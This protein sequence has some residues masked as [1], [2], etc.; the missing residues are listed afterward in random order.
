M[1][2]PITG[3][4]PI[5]IDVTPGALADAIMLVVMER[6]GSPDDAGCDWYTDV[7]GNTYIANQDWI[8]SV[9]PKVAAL[10][11]AANILKYDKVLKVKA[12][13]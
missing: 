8:V 10:V 13:V 2:V 11:D 1:K 7:E 6:T 9:Q 4:Q 3:V 5:E 12:K